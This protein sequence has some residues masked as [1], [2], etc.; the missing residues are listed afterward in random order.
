MYVTTNRFVQSFLNL[1]SFR[2]V[3]GKKIFLQA[4]KIGLRFIAMDF[5]DNFIYKQL[6]N[7]NFRMI[8]FF[9][10]GKD[11]KLFFLAD[12]NRKSCS[13][14]WSTDRTLEATAI[15]LAPTFIIVKTTI[16]SR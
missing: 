10:C 14:N 7:I 16:L 5:D 8:F 6:K 11:W 2:T 13:P 1:F 4:T 3:N 9:F 12:Q 15:D